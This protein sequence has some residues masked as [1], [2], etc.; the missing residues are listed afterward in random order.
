MLLTDPL[1]WQLLH[2]DLLDFTPSQHSKV[3]DVDLPLAGLPRVKS[4]ATA[5]RT[6]SEA[7]LHLLEGD[8]L[9]NAC[10]PTPTPDHREPTALG[11]SIRLRA[12][13]RSHPQLEGV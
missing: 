5:V 2:T 11:E 9:L 7:E 10:W 12:G 13:A 1:A 3:Y 8:R 4:G 6:G